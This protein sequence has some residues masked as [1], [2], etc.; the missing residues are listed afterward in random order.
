MLGVLTPS[1]ANNTTG[2][3][4]GEITW[5][6]SVT[7]SAIEHLGE[8]ETITER[9]TITVDDQQGGQTPQV[10]EITIT[11]SNDAPVLDGANS[12][13]VGLIL[14]D[15]TTPTLTSSGTLVLSDLDRR[16]THSTTVTP[17]AGNSLGGTLTMAAVVGDA[18]S[19]TSSVGWTY[20]I[21]N[22]ATQFLAAGQQIQESFVV[23]ISDGDGGS[24]SQTITVT[25]TG[26][27]DAPTITAATDV[28][29]DVTE[30]PDGD[31]LEGNTTHSQ[32]GSFLI[33]D[34]DLDDIQ[35]VSVTASST[36]AGSVLGVLTPS[37]ANNTTG[38]G[39]GEISWSYSIADSAIDELAS[40]E[41]ITETFTLTV[42]DQN[43]GTVNQN[44]VITITGSN[45]APTITAATDVAGAI[46]EISDGAAGENSAAHS[47]SGSFAIADM[48]LADVQ[49]VSVSNSTTT[50]TRGVLG[51]LTPSIAN[52]TT[53]DGTGVIA[54][55]YSIDDS[56]ID[57]LADGETIS[58]TFTVT[59]NDQKG[60]TISQDVTIELS[61][62]NDGTKITVAGGD[63]VLPALPRAMPPHYSPA[64]LSRPQIPITVTPPRSI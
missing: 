19:A 18:N 57:Y 20:S 34:A 46:T 38:D 16:N 47:E 50:G 26:E 9:F 14:E 36:T 59:V 21:D 22:A 43:G 7:D 3:G 60:G 8:G 1:V 45:D 10:V 40:G 51:E 52:N 32:A 29:G 62:R 17:D 37:V 49:D 35:T 4:S 27:A 41:T 15:A 53:G 42:D 23:A 63:S 5:S 39:S 44:V 25:I 54:W 24:V 48:D 58:E 30:I 61:G 13:T 6:Y 55:T 2:D 12:H 31:P 56:A 33:A 64:A 11:G 28:T